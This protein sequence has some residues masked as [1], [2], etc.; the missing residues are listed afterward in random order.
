MFFFLNNDLT[1]REFEVQN[2]LFSVNEYLYFS[3]LILL[4]VLHYLIF[5][6]L[7]I[8]MQETFQLF[9][10]RGDNKIH[11]SQIGNALRALGQNP[12]ESDVK[13]FTHQHKPG[14]VNKNLFQSHALISIFSL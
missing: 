1:F 12:T 9:D 3:L 13:K 11:I 2:K 14:K 7:L 8:E 4:F 5:G 6:I 10:S